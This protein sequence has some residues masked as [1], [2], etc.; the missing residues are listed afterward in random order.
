MKPGKLSLALAVAIGIGFI[1][2]LSC[3]NHRAE[4]EVSYGNPD[5]FAQHIQTD[6]CTVKVGYGNLCI[7]NVPENVLRELPI[8]GKN[9]VF[10]SGM[11]Q[12]AKMTHITAHWP[13]D[14]RN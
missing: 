10:T 3:V 9:I 13:R 1:L 8:Q 11:G 5:V 4:Y 6:D 7:R 14:W 12:A 2:S